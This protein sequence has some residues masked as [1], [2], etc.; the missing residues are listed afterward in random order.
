VLDNYNILSVGVQTDISPTYF[1]KGNYAITIPGKPVTSGTYKISGTSL[2]I[3]LAYIFT[4][5]NKRL[6]RQYE[7]TRNL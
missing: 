5:T 3:S 2:G 1:L 4:G 6:V 7:K